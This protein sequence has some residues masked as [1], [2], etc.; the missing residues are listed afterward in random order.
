MYFCCKDY[1]PSWLWAEHRTRKKEKQQQ[2]KLTQRQKHW[3][4]VAYKGAW[5]TMQDQAFSSVHSVSEI[6]KTIVVP[7]LQLWSIQSSA[8]LLLLSVSWLHFHAVLFSFWN[9]S[10]PR[11]CIKS[12]LISVIFTN[13][14][15]SY[16][17]ALIRLYSRQRRAST[18]SVF[19]DVDNFPDKLN[20]D[21]TLFFFK[22]CLN[23]N[24]FTCLSS[25]K[26]WKWFK[27]HE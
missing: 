24:Y 4:L 6:R 22:Q 17:Q 19:C 12:K 23:N 5:P 14:F 8:L 27:F 20:V 26:E 13:P 2:Q 18:A 25:V 1:L 7:H 16:W 10:T 3:N 21:L 9:D 11:P 15:S